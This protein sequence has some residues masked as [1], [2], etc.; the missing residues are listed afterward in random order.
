MV[1]GTAQVENGEERS[2]L[3]RTREH[4]SSTTFELRE[5][6]GNEV[7]R[8]VL[9]AG[10][11]VALGL[12]VEKLAHVLAGSITPGGGLVDGNLPRFAVTRLIAALHTC[13]LDVHRFSSLV[14]T[15][16]RYQTDMVRHSG[17]NSR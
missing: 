11:E 1:A 10:I 3:A 5:T 7:V 8:G 16:T 6:R 12:E 14:R 17:L 2:G 4:R 15:D 9:Q 13:G